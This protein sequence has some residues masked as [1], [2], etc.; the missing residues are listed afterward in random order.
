MIQ[1]LE[2]ILM[3]LGMIQIDF[4]SREYNHYMY[5]NTDIH[6]NLILF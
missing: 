2:R 3:I 5:C 6:H 1:K 4:F